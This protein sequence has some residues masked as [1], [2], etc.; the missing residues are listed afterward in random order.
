MNSSKKFD[1]GKKV[2]AV[3]RIYPTKM[4]VNKTLVGYEICYRTKSG[5]NDK[6]VENLT[7]TKVNTKLCEPNITE[8]N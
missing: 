4:D 8:T 6:K 3:D 2:F 1:L 7:L 5:H